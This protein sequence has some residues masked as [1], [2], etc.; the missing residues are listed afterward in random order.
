MGVALQRMG[1]FYEQLGQTERQVEVYRRSLDIFNRL[2]REQPDEDWNKFDAAISYDSLGEVGR[3]I[4]KEPAHLFDFYGRS[5][6]LRKQLVA[7]V[8]SPNPGLFQRRRALAVSYVKLGML[9]LEVGDPARAGGYGAQA[10]KE[11][12]AAAALDAGKVY[13]RQELLSS[14]Y[15]LLGRAGCRLGAE[16]EARRHY[17]ECAALRRAMVQADPLNTY[18]LQELGRVVDALGDLEVEYGHARAGLASYEEAR[19]LFDALCRKD[20]G[21]S[22]FRWYRANADYHIGN[23]RQLLGEAAAARRHYRECLPVREQLLKDD[24][25]NI[26]RRIE[27]M[28]VQARLG[29]HEAAAKT[30]AAVCDYA[31]RHPGK[32]F[33]AACGYALCVPAVSTGG[34]PSLPQAYGHKALEA[35]RQAMA[36]GF[37]DGRALDAAPDLEPVRG[38]K[39]WKAVRSGL[40]K[41]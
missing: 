4:E 36:C 23:A 5:L 17:Q 26:Q 15:L 11:S 30:A 40:A 29:D 25:K 33:S 22:E 39:D 14:S 13:D 12:Q 8:H 10:L 16:A 24:P 34:D 9:S 35:L 28:L 37:R 18:A 31:P 19:A 20:P 1:T 3:E 6:D 38:E 32:L 7:A 41:Q 27:L 2:M 21:N